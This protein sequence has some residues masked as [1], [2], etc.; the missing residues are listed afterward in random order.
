MLTSGLAADPASTSTLPETISIQRDQFGVPHI[1]A[2][3]DAGAYYAAGYVAAQDRLY[4]MLMT[5]VIMEGRAAEFFYENAGDKSLVRRDQITR[6]HGWKRH[7]IRTAN[8]LAQHE[9][10]L[11]SLLQAYCDGV[12]LYMSDP[13]NRA[14][15]PMLIQF[16]LPSH[17]PWT[18][19]DCLLAWYSIARQFAPIDGNE[20]R[21]REDWDR[22]R[23]TINP[24]T[25]VRYTRAEILEGAW[26]SCFTF[27]QPINQSVPWLA[28]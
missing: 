19:R 7:A 13:A 9:P 17:I 16:P 21:E 10:E 20:G 3:S 12:N 28:T 26:G 6:L 24:L 11:H 2:A 18:V 5:R 25:G 14:N 15:H 22:L 4:Q 1:Y 27:A 23:T 8:A